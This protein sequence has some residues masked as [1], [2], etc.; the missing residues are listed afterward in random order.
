MKKDNVE[1]F[2]ASVT[3]DRINL[4]RDSHE[5]T[6]AEMKPTAVKKNNNKRV[7]TKED[8]VKPDPT[9][10]IM[11]L[12]KTVKGKNKSRKGK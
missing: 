8:A 2:D 5:R 12:K 1:F 4:I 11:D 10:T 9:V 6:S 7:K 3:N